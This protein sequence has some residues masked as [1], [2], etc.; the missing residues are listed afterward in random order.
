MH[1]TNIY[2]VCKTQNSSK[3]KVT[4]TIIR[5]ILQQSIATMSNATM[6]LKHVKLLSAHVINGEYVVRYTSLFQKVILLC[7]VVLGVSLVAKAILLRYVTDYISNA[8][9]LTVK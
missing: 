6:N 9:L 3:I 8:L 1:E 4:I 5:S 7:N 2:L